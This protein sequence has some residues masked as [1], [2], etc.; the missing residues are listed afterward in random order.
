MTLHSPRIADPSYRTARWIGQWLR[1]DLRAAVALAYICGLAS[2][3]IL[4]SALA[5]YSPTD[6]DLDAILL[7]PSIGHLLG[8]DDVGRDI[9]SR[10]LHGAPISIFA[11]MMA[12]SI[13]VILGMPIG[14]CA[15]FF[16]GRLDNVIGR[17]IE[18]LSSF[19]GMVLAIGVTGALGVGLV[20]S[21][22]AVG[23]VFSP[24]IARLARAQT[25]VVKN[26]LYVDAARTFGASTLRVIWRHVLPN[27]M[28]PVIVQV[29]LL[30]AIALLVESSLSFLGLGVQPPYPSWGAML[31]RAYA[32][33]EIAP[34]QMYPPGIAILLTA[35]AFN[36][37]GESLRK[38]LDPKLRTRTVV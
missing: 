30:L 2:L 4:A 26:E 32:N 34:G 14:V 11:S 22:I 38:A 1:S 19:P 8:T 5:P 7:G 10:L 17:L 28:Q 31:A 16:G 18:T 27:A 6:Q 33:M 36:T 35:L 37:L 20:N 13:G 23:I 12:V 21:M 15:G 3:A 9:L 29:T 24:E 25:M